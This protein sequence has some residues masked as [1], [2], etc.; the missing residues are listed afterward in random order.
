[1]ESGPEDAWPKGWTA[2]AAKLE[3][4]WWVTGGAYDEDEGILDTTI[5]LV[6]GEW[7]AIVILPEGVY[8]HCVVQL[9]NTHV[10][11]SWGY[12]GSAAAASSFI[13]REREG[14]NQQVDMERER[15]NH[16]CVLRNNVVWGAGGY[17]DSVEIFSLS[18]KSWR[19]G[20]SLPFSAIGGELVDYDG[21]LIFLGGYGDN[22]NRIFQLEEKDMVWR[23]VGN[24]E[25]VGVM[26]TLL[27]RNSKN[28][29]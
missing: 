4:G 14:F 3:G 12:N 23:E 11:Y 9:N 19:V 2:A 25:T 1:M 27:E 7:R 6:N 17:S 26:F 16:G 22:G 13:Y 10:F 15:N 24:M 8:N 20:P 28:C 5:I 18:S 21:R 29:F